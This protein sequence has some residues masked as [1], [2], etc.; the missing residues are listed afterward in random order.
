[1]TLSVAA[2][3]V[4]GFLHAC[5]NGVY[6]GDCQTTT[7]ILGPYYRSG[8]PER[9]NLLR[10]GSKGEVLKLS[11]KIMA[12]NCRQVL[13]GATVDIW[14]CDD[15]G[16]YDT[17]SDEF[18]HRGKVRTN[19]QGEY[20]FTTVIPVP[21][22]QE[23]NSNTFR[24][25]HIHMRIAAPEYQDLITQI[26]FLNDPYL[27]K[28]EFS[29]SPKAQKR[30]LKIQE[31]DNNE[32][33]VTFDI[34]MIEQP[35]LDESALNKLI[36]VY[37]DAKNKTYKS[38]VFKRESTLWINSPEGEY[39]WNG[40]YPWQ[41]TGNHTFVKYGCEKSSVKFSSLPDSP[42]IMDVNYHCETD[43]FTIRM[44]KDQ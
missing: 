11:G 2:V 44:I 16:K 38:T 13:K 28:D 29:A 1:V 37:R 42:Q 33:K 25:A 26:Y 9:S 17:T 32:K 12:P 40:E 19:E 6:Q 36:G 30:I 15:K 14:H 7:D 39:A 41:Y 5:A 3:Y 31:G 21:Y 23:P 8:A 35:P 20:A 34:T 18:A 4:P 27:G 43:N 24:P 10:A 22:E